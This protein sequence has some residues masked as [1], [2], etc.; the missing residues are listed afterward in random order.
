MKKLTALLLAAVL[1]F[2]GIAGCGSTSSGSTD[3]SASK[4]ESTTAA[5]ETATASQADSGEKIKI[6]L[7]ASTIAGNELYTGT[8]IP[9]FEAEAEKLG[10]E[11][12]TADGKSDTNTQI[13]V[14]EN[15]IGM[16][17][18]VNPAIK[19][20]NTLVLFAV[21]PLNIIK[22]VAVSVVTMFVYKPLSVI[23]KSGIK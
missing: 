9:S 15:L 18:A 17:T 13:S 14:L 16:G 4:A 19:D 21:V 8:V 10:V 20:V 1:A 2:A 3:S 7:V 22:G 11:F 6:G 12:V 5:S 23:I